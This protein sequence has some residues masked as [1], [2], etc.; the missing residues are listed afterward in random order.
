[1]GAQIE[2]PEFGRYTKINV[3]ELSGALHKEDNNGWETILGRL[4]EGTA[5]CNAYVS[6]NINTKLLRVRQ[7]LV[8]KFCKMINPDFV[9]RNKRND[10]CSIRP[11]L[12]HAT[13]LQPS[14]DFPLNVEKIERLSLDRVKYTKSMAGAL[15][16]LHW[17]AKVDCNNVNFVLA[18][19][20]PVQQRGGI[21]VFQNG[22]LGEHA[23]WL[24]NFD[25]CK[26]LSMDE[27]G[28]EKATISF[29]LNSLSPK[30]RVL[31]QPG[32]ADLGCLQG[33]VFYSQQLHPKQGVWKTGYSHDASPSIGDGKYGP[34]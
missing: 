28:A 10:R 29:W 13:F 7:P 32:S 18:L 16:L 4:P 3:P 30:A 11:Y 25:R 1:M 20:R 14:R 24:L 31:Q 27:G 8:Q 23:L 21:P 33:R 26:P 12:A 5:P 34:A 19:R 17:G 15:A 9:L 22:A 2:G 6:E